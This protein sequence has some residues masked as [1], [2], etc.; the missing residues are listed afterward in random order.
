MRPADDSRIIDSV[1]PTSDTNQDP[2]N[3]KESEP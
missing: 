3:D 1:A 2:T